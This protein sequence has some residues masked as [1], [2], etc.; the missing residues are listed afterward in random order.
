VPGPNVSAAPRTAKKT[1]RFK[2]VEPGSGASP[3][4]MVSAESDLP[5]PAALPEGAWDCP[6][7]PGSSPRGEGYLPGLP[8][9]LVR[10]P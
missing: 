7:A 3:Q 1:L 6:D 8:V 9:L 10:L 5:R 4:V 2:T